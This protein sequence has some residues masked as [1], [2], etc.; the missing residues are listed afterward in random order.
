[1]IKNVFYF[2]L[3]VIFVLERYLNVCPE[4]FGHVG[5]RLNKKAKVNFKTNYITTYVTIAI[6][7][8]CNIS[9]SKANQTLKFGHLI[10]YNVRKNF[11]Q[12]SCRKSGR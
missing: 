2:I 5:K 1:M 8:F 9:R 7:I 12:N 6:R 10:E 11:L 3:K 4:L